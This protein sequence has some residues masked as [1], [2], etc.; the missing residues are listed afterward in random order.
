MLTF[1]PDETIAHDLDPRS[2]LAFQFAFAIAA[3][4]RPA[5]ASLVALSILVGCVLASAGLSPIRVLAEHRYLYVILGFSVLIAAVTLGP[6]WID[7]GDGLRTAHAAYGVG[8]VF[9]VSAAYVRSTP[10]RQSRAAIQRLVPGAPGR[11]LGIG[12]SLVFRFL[13]VVR[14]DIRTIR[15]AM[16]IRLGT[17]RSATDRAARL[18]ARGLTRAFE[19]ADRLSVAL[20]ARCLS[21]NATLPPLSFSRIDWLVFA[22]SIAV[23]TSP[24]W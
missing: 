18:S 4:A 3:I 12:V 16:A 2:K 19:R 20:Q 24:L 6:P 10:V 15:Q 7:V 9:L 23:G 17:E 13:P 14:R 11:L 1:E 22:L 21:W 8:L 5:P